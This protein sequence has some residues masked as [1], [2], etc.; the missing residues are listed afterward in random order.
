MGEKREISV[1]LAHLKPCHGR[2]RPPASFKEK[3][4][5]PALDPPDE[6]QQIIELYAVDRVAG[7]KLG[8]GRNNLHNICT[9]GA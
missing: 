5:L 2:E 8:P 7:N 6:A 1:H 4:T 9:A 3:K